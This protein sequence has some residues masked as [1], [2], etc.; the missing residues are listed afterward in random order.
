MI[1]LDRQLRQLMDPLQLT[2]LDVQFARLICRLASD[3][4]IELAVAAALT[5][6]R[7]GQGDV[8]C[9]LAQWECRCLLQGSEE[10]IRLPG[11]HCWIERLGES[12]VVGD[13][14]EFTPLVLDPDGRLYLHRY[15][16]YENSIAVQLRQRAAGMVDGIDR[17][18][19]RGGLGR[20]FPDSGE[21][22]T[23]WQKV[24]AAVSALRHLSIIS[25]GPGTG[26]TSTVVRILTL[27]L[28]Q[29]GDDPVNIALVAPTGKAAA[30]L[31]ESI[32]HAKGRLQGW[33]GVT[34]R[35]PEE[36]MTIHRL[37]GSRH[38]SVYFRHHK[39]NPLPCDLLI[40]DEVSMVDVAL[41]AKLLD[42]LKESA[43]IILLGDRNQLASV[44][45]GA[46]LSDIC[47]G[48]SGYSHGFSNQLSG[49]VGQ[50]IAQSGDDLNTLGDSIVELRHSYRFG[51]ESGIGRLAE[52]V[53]SGESE[54]ALGLLES[55]QLADIELLAP[56]V[57]LVDEVRNGY[58]DYFSAVRSSSSAG[59][60]FEAFSRFRILTATR[61]GERGVSGL[62]R[63][64][65][66]EFKSEIITPGQGDWYHG[67]PIL[68]LRN[69]HN[70]RLYNGD[71]GILVQ[72]GE[73]V[74]ACFPA[75]EGYRL[76]PVSRLPEHETAFAMTVHKSQGSEFERVLL[77]FPDRDLPLLT[78]ELLYTGLTRARRKFRLHAPRELVLQSIQRKVE[79]ASGLKKTLWQPDNQQ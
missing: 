49:L 42:A 7:T 71:V 56:D 60:L 33:E 40:V 24:A 8:C 39:K 35:I 36:T 57:G 45:A 47:G 62:N 70:Q 29:A 58:R 5:C 25:G 48:W 50:Q 20:L 43:R 27:L 10:E 61:A 3:E 19:L 34:D 68:I 79:R 30:R 46:V 74:R 16:R 9:S 67:R 21:M 72:E 44:E 77:V 75:Q 63:L 53:V 11:L 37:L 18:L 23:D 28:Q 38:N 17:E 6:S 76:L 54:T 73:T 64:V 65:E 15:W 52:A 22:S 32:R 59:D 1:P 14:A 12:S 31:Q 51:S 4:S 55:G 69:D 41:M 26:K 2:E 13:G 66:N 78:R